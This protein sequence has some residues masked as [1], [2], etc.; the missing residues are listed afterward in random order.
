[1]WT[2]PVYFDVD[3]LRQLLD[4]S[5]LRNAQSLT[6]SKQPFNFYLYYALLPTIQLHLPSTFSF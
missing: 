2:K 6:L 4:A 3:K 1:M 5:G